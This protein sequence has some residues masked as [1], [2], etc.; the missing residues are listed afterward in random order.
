MGNNDNEVTQLQTFLPDNIHGEISDLKD[1]IAEGLTWPQFF[2]GLA[3]NQKIKN[4]IKEELEKEYSKG[5]D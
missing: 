5:E 4:T 3:N 1:D 2:K